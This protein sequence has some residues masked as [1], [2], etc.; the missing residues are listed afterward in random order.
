MLSR[1]RI[2]SAIYL[3]HRLDL[4]AVDVDLCC[5]NC[6]GMRRI[7]EKIKIS[8]VKRFVAFIIR[9]F[10]VHYAQYFLVVSLKVKL[11]LLEQQ[12]DKPFNISVFQR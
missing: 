4:D 6:G 2:L 1:D 10:P 8:I 7:E 11:L 5:C 12:T 3:R 9:P